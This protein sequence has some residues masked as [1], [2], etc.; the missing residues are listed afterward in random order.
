[1]K[2]FLHADDLSYLCIVKKYQKTVRPTTNVY[3]TNLRRAIAV[4]TMVC[5][6]TILS[7]QNTQTIRHEVTAGETLYSLSRKYGVSIADIQKAN[8]GLEETILAGQTLVI[9]TPSTPAATASQGAAPTTSTPD[10]GSRGVAIIPTT[11]KATAGEVRTAVESIPR[12]T[13]LA[14]GEPLCKQMH[15]VKKKETLYGISQLYGLTVDELIAANPPLKDKKL[16]KGQTIC[17][18][19]TA[20]ELAAMQPVEEEE[21]IVVKEPVPV[22]MAVIMPF[23]LKQEKKTR[24]AITMIDFYEGIMLAIAE[25]KQDGLVCHVMA[26]DEEQ[27]DSVLALPRM[28]DVKLIIGGK[29]QNNI[30]K[31]KNFAERNNISLVVP[32]SSATSLV[33]N[34]RNVYQVNQKMENDTYTR[35][36]DSFSAMYPYA[37]YIFVNIE[38]QTDKIDNV[39]RMKNYLNSEN[40]SYHNINFTELDDIIELLAEGKE[41]IVVPTSSTKTAFDRLTKKLG[42][43]E[44]DAYNIDLLGY[45]DWQAFADKEPELFRKYNCMFFTSFY[46]NPNA[47][48]TY[49]FNQKF[50]ATFGRD[51][52]P[53]YPHYGMLGYDIANFFVMNMYVEGEDF[54]PNIEN[55][56]S[57]ALQNPMHFSHKNTWSGFVNNAMMFV[58]FESD[59]KISVKQ[60]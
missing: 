47:S 25:L 31:L 4:V 2:K 30:E 41:N 6:P 18:P 46:N 8:P 27:I 29:D 58:R 12:P 3:A 20:A 21:E 51:Q 48:E 50:R 1:M 11:D 17:I 34:T 40:V 39:V 43:L 44:L 55:L 38:D 37:N 53:T 59:G 49:A 19:Y 36:F 52:L 45:P 22:N 5:L 7:A 16:K 13:L 54:A 33:N 23:G 42:E 26:Y 24:E 57:H 14:E 9:P 10:S 56:E 15:E 32:L 28:K 60:L 35:A